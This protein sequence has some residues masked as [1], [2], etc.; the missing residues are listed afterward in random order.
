MKNNEEVTPIR[1]PDTVGNTYIELSESLYRLSENTDFKKVFL[2]YYTKEYASD[3]VSLLNTPNK[4][5]RAD[6]IELLI[7]IANFQDFIHFVHNMAESTRA[8]LLEGEDNAE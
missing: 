3:R 8:D 2:D 5:M 6:I 1:I 4:G 7:S